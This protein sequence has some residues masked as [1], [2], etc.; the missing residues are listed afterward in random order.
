VAT[1][2][3]DFHRRKRFANDSS[4]NNRNSILCVSLMEVYQ[5]QLKAIFIDKTVPEFKVRQFLLKSEKKRSNVIMIQTEQAKANEVTQ[6]FDE[7]INMNP[8]EYILWKTWLTYNTNNKEIIMEAHNIYLDDYKLIN[9]PGF[10][11][12]GTVQLEKIKLE[13]GETD[14]S[15]LNLNKFIC[16]HYTIEGQD[17]CRSHG[18]IFRNPIV[19]ITGTSGECWEKIN[20][21][22]SI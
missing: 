10:N 21:I 15:N 2:S 17:I 9:L 4:I 19:Y 8:H 11:D 6:Q 22:S 3:S 12:V 20:Q 5:Q 7:V 14:Y 16:N 1:N 18:T 13:K